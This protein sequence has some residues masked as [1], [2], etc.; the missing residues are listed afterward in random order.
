MLLDMALNTAV[1]ARICVSK[2]SKTNKYVIEL[3]RYFEILPFILA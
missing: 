2:S 1:L 3:G